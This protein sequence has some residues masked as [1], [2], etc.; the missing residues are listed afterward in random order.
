[1]ENY[2]KYE[3]MQRSI[4]KN[5]QELTEFFVDTLKVSNYYDLLTEIIKAY[6]FRA[7]AFKRNKNEAIKI[8]KEAEKVSPKF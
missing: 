5:S 1:M 3:A 4:D 2:E 8:Y 6:N 7:I